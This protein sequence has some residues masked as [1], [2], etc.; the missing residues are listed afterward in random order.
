MEAAS[1]SEAAN[2]WNIQIY[3][4]AALKVA[5]LANDLAHNETLPADYQPLTSS[6]ITAGISAIHVIREELDDLE[7]DL[8]DSMRTLGITWECIARAS[9]RNER[10]ARRRARRLWRQ[11]PRSNQ[12]SRRESLFDT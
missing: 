6:E 4:S 1:R 12:E 10:G 8:L 3:L 11:H 5:Y 2:I 7:A 9:G